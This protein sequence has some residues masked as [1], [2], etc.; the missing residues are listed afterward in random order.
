LIIAAIVGAILISIAVYRFWATGT[1]SVEIGFA[2]V[3]SVGVLLMALPV[4][5]KISINL[6][7]NKSINLDLQNK[8]PEKNNCALRNIVKKENAEIVAR[9]TKI[10]ND[11]IL[12]SEKILA[13][14]EAVKKRSNAMKETQSSQ[15]LKNID[16][17]I[18]YTSQ[19]KDNAEAVAKKLRSSYSIVYTENSTLVEVEDNQI[20][21]KTDIRSNGLLTFDIKS[22]T[23]Y[24]TSAL[25]D[26][27]VLVTNTRHTPRDLPGEI[28]VLMY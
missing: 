26:L 11:N 4:I 28:Q 8:S 12:K 20:P 10:E 24:I 22:E 1:T 18:Y 21:G 3:I 27:G 19:R 9:L 6:S 5:E 2:A 17:R 7:E 23:D 16:I 13:L 15:E 25:K 14:E